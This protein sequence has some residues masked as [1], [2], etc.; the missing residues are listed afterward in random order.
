M[1]SHYALGC[2]TDRPGLKLSGKGISLLELDENVGTLTEQSFFKDVINPSYLHYN[3]EDK[4]L[5]SATENGKGTGCLSSFCLSTSHGLESFSH[6]EGPGRSNCHI[7]RDPERDLAFVASYKDGRL[8]VYSMKEGL[9]LENILDYPYSGKGPNEARQE[10]SHAHQAV[11]SPNNQFLY[12]ADLGSDT[13]WIHDLNRIEEAPRGV[14][15]SPGVGPRHMV[16]HPQSNRLYVVCELIP[17]LLVYE[18]NETDGKLTLLQKSRTVEEADLSIAQPS[19]IKIHPSGQ[20]LVLANRFSDT[21]TIF[22]LNKETGLAENRDIIE[23][24]GT[25]CRDLE[26]SPSGRWLMLAHQ[27]SCDIQ[28]CQFDENLGQPTGDWGESF[29]TGSPTCLV[30][31]TSV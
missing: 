18:W 21:I 14:K 16:F 7:N 1:K 20:T 4:L 13:L 2:Y 9:F 19:G 3:Q 10:Q 31:L 26:F 5:L 17:T 24:R 6:I 28:L 29:E 22:K 11:L 23:S 27:E 12:V 8:K 25:H 15:T 30:S